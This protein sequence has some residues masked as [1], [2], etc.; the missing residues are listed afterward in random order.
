[1]Q[2]RATGWP[3]VIAMPDMTIEARDLT[4]RY[5][6]TI[7]VD[8][9][10]FSVRAGSV[11][12]FV[13]PNG[14][15]KSTTL[16]MMPALDNPDSGEALLGG[17]HHRTFREPALMVGALLDAEAVHPG[18]RAFDHLLWMA[19]YNGL[20]RR[21]VGEVLE[22][23]GLGSV[24]GKRVGGFSLGMRQRLGIAGALLGDPPVLI[25]AEPVTGPGPE[26]IQ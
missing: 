15:G 2:A 5:G 23:V 13:G 11:T 21:R 20:P 25:L 18:R 8:R 17:R 6:P 10:S 1:L 16:R 9:L 7:A 12:G 26:G 3:T 22:T 4:K 14:A 19:Q 24:A